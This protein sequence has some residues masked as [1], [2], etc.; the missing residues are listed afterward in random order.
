MHRLLIVLL[1]G[2]AG[3]CAG[4]TY[5]YAGP[6]TPVASP[7]RP[8]PYVPRSVRGTQ[9]EPRPGCVNL[10][11]YVCEAR[12]PYYV[13]NQSV[14]VDQSTD[15][16]VQ[17]AGP[18]YTDWT[19]RRRAELERRRQLDRARQLQR[20]PARPQREPALRG[21]RDRV[22]PGRAWDAG[23]SGRTRIAGTTGRTWSHRVAR[24]TGGARLAGN[25]RR[26]GTGWP[27]RTY[28]LTGR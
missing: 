14:L 13:E 24:P 9:Y 27:A 1:T 21:T 18:V 11:P 23:A 12:R 22:P 7:H 8:H 16:R 6:M 19:V 4:Q 20:A 2:L 5:Y 25:A 3:G 15:V 17:F 26:A 28:R 10:N